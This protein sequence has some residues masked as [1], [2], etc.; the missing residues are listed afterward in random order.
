MREESPKP[1]ITLREED[2][3]N[4]INPKLPP[5]QKADKLCA[6]AAKNRPQIDEF[7]AKIDKKFKA[8]SSSN[9]KLKVRILDKAARPDILKKKSWFGVEHIRDSLRFRTALDDF[10]DLPALVADLIELGAKIVKTETSKMLD[11]AEWGWRAVMYDI[12]LEDGQLVEYYITF[13]EMMDAN[14]DPHHALYEKWRNCTAEQVTARIVERGKDVDA[15]NDAFDNALETYF[16]RTGQNMG[17]I[18]AAC[19]AADALTNN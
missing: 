10:K 16:K 3:A 13:K 4:P 7:I 5:D 12:Q 17:D 8:K 9:C 6:L 11:P 19:K 1:A 2:I 14:D 18:E 15:S